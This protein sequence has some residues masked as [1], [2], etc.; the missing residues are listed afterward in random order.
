VPI[1]PLEEIRPGLEATALT[2]LAGEE[3]DSFRVEILGA[4][5]RGEAGSH[6]ILVRALD[7]RLQR[8]GIAAGMSGS[9]LYIDG[10]LVGALAFSFIGATEPLGAATPIGEMLAELDAA[11][12]GAGAGVPESGRA[13][14]V[15]AGAEAHGFPAWREAWIAEAAEDAWGAL[16]LPAPGELPA[17]LQPIALPLFLGG[18]LAPGAAGEAR[19]WERIGLEPMPLAGLSPT[20]GAAGAEIA[21][22]AMH[23]AARLRP[24]D[25]FG[26]SLISGDMEAAAIGT[27]TWLDGDRL[28][29]LGHPFMQIS[30]AEFAIRRAKIHTIIPTREV[31]FKVGSPLEEVGRLWRDGRPG[32]A[33]ELG[34][35]ARQIP[36][37]V[38]IVPRPGGEARRYH[39]EVARHAILSPALLTVAL[40]S[41]VTVETHVI[42]AA[43]LRTRVEVLLDDGRR[44]MRE[45]FFETLG[46]GQTAAVLLAPVA[47]L[48][49][50]S[51]APFTVAAVE[52]TIESLPEVRAV[53]IEQIR[54]PRPAVRPGETLDVEILLR[55]HLGGEE[56]RRVR[57]A[58]PA[59]LRGQRLRV[60]VGSP[61]AFFEWDR[62]RAPQKYMPRSLEDLLTQIREYP[63]DEM[64]IVR[65]YG[66]SRGV[67]LQ[68][69]E[70]A[71]LPLSK[72]R[73]LQGGTSGGKSAPVGGVILD[74]QRIPM[75][76]VVI[77]GQL[78]EVEVIW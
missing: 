36:L 78:V 44:I 13:S 57:L 23:G 76:A 31:S 70:L 9:P 25:A 39:F 17:G 59:R 75:D 62:E 71:S 50:T 64:L 28:L 33:G 3:P 73:T 14:Q 20:A 22:P 49:G 46:P 68:G 45:D 55:R 42:G 72:W 34:V 66:P 43:S 48:A 52:V 77:G 21:A 65:L 58:V 74:E 29:G 51:L 8:T 19:L 61:E 41:A 27:V 6:L 30:P 5:Q 35:R 4:L 10:R 11:G 2:V 38:T 18:R 1:Y 37:A 16:G 7:E 24:G 60:M 56:W 53:Q 26:I 47:Y 69:Q 32:V 15:S 54:V 67:V 12:L 40:R 63:S